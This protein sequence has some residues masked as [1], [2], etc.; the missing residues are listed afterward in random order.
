MGTHPIFES[1]F[2]CLTERNFIRQS[3]MEAENGEESVI[4]ETITE[5]VVEETIEET[6]EETLEDQPVQDDDE[7]IMEE[8]VHEEVVEDGVGEDDVQN[9]EVIHD[10]AV[11]EEVVGS[12]EALNE[13]S[14]D[15][16]KEVTDEITLPTESAA[17][18]NSDSDSDDDTNQPNLNDDRHSDSDSDDEKPKETIASDD[19]EP[20]PKTGLESSDDE[21]EKVE[22]KAKIDS[23]SDDD[24]NDA[25]KKRIFG[26]DSGSE[27]EKEGEST[28][29]LQQDDE[30]AGDGTIQSSDDERPVDAGQGGLVSDFDLMMDK[31]KEEARM[32]RMKGKKSDAMFIGDADDS[33]NSMLNRMKEAADSDKL[34][35]SKRLPALKKLSMLKEVVKN[36]SKHDLN[37]MLIENGVMSAIADWI[38][39]LP[40]KSLP[41]LN[42][43]ME[44][45]RV[46]KMYTNVSAET[47]KHSGIGKAVMLLY[48]HP[49]EVRGN[50]E[51]CRELIARWSRPIYGL[52]DN[53]Q[54]MT[55]EA[56]EA[57]DFELLPKAKKRRL[58]E[59]AD[60]RVEK[61]A[62][63]DK[64]E[65]KPGRKGFVVRARV[66]MPS[67]QDYVVR[68]KW[69]VDGADSDD[70]EA[71]DETRPR[72][73]QRKPRN[74][75]KTKSQAEER[76]DRQLKR[77]MDMKRAQR[78]AK[79]DTVQLQRIKL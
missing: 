70:D 36:I 4:E 14:N 61:N 9:E 63:E 23:D 5:E 11:Q 27:D 21:D 28:S 40:D 59:A 74:Q 24:D 1:D 16:H 50:K 71:A 15:G 3:K 12:E 60:G 78:V 56:R 48:K 54:S 44:L 73:K 62:T 26:E 68:P 45:L 37:E 7:P 76:L 8:T 51:I 67:N 38:S 18:N 49:K 64:P 25:E 29:N 55:R 75:L 39:P 31:K 58:K 77:Q 22:K 53:Y 41:S 43:R 47:L 66:P 10:E 13:E 17:A 34:S 2:D 57:R 33:I 30:P 52:N 6:V 35:N 46:L 32:K 72:K 19:E 65:P 20:A 69:N 42:I 79:G